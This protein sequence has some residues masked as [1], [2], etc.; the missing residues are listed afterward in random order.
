LAHLQSQQWQPHFNTRIYD[1][2]WSGLPLRAVPGSPI[3]MYSDPM[4]TSWADTPLLQD[5]EYFQEVLAS[6]QCPLLA[7]RLLR[8]GAGSVIKEHRDPMLSPEDGDVRIHVVVST[9]PDVECRIDGVNHR[10]AAGEC[11]YGNFTLPHSFANRGTTERFH[12]VLDCKVDDW[13]RGLLEA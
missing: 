12:I 6:F 9:N 7:V 11:W 3:P 5:C 10:W 1:G 4:A 13:L 8:L 2:D